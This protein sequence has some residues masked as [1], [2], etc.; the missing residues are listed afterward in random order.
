MAKGADMSVLGT[1]IHACIGL[2]F[3]DRNVSLSE[4]EVENILSGFGV[5]E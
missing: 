1:A 3:T 2:S 4:G 5:S